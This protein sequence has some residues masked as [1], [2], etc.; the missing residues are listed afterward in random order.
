M[1]GRVY[2]SAIGRFISADPYIQ[3]NGV[4]ALLLTQKDW[5]K[6]KTGDILKKRY[7]KIRKGT[8]QY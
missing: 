7:V 5:I 2:D 4:G 8:K 1:N 6:I 3:I